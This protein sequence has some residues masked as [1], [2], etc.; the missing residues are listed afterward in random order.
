M[1]DVVAQCAPVLDAKSRKNVISDRNLAVD[2]YWN[3]RKC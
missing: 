1:N 2:I 3:T